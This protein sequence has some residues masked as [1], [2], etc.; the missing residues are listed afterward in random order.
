MSRVGKKPVL[1]PTA[2]SAEYNT[3]SKVLV[4]KGPLGTLQFSV[5]NNAQVDIVDSSIQVTVINPLD[6]YQRALWGTTRAVINNLVE[7]VFKGYEKEL[8]LN[9]VGFRMELAKQLTLYIGFSHPV[10]VDIPSDVK[11]TLEKN[12]L[13]GTSIDKQSIGNFFSYIHNM[14]P[15]D[16]YKQKGFKFPGRFYRKKVGKKGK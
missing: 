13:K 1:L 9:G 5:A 4:V 10:V 2:V 12:V 16:V 7:G 8:E 6:R 14:K 11:L 3:T 15:C